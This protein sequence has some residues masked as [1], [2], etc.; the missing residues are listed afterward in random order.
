[1]NILEDYGSK[2]REDDAPGVMVSVKFA[3]KLRRL[4]PIDKRQMKATILNLVQRH[5]RVMRAG[6]LNVYLKQHNERFRQ[7][8]L[9]LCRAKLWNRGRSTVA[10]GMEYGVWQ[11]VD[12]TL[13]KI[14]RKMV[15][16]KERGLRY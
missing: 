10:R 4:T 6:A 7:L 15:E 16:H 1:M 5:G 2:E 14:E 8:P 3:G 9:F 11:T 12:N 13:D